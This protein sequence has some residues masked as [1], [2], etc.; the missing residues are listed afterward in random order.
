M[1]IQSIADARA[2]IQARMVLLGARLLEPQKREA[3]TAEALRLRQA[4]ESA[5]LSNMADTVS[6]GLTTILGWAAEWVGANPAE[7]F[8]TLNQEFSDTTMSEDEAVQVATRWQMGACTEDDMFHLYRQGG[9]IEPEITVEQWKLKRREQMPQPAPLPALGDEEDEE[10]D[11]AQREQ[12]E[13]AV[14]AA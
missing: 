4:G 3:E 13:D 14:G 6:W 10:D 11:D 8:I 2:A 5:T 12:D 9:R 7:N 1:G